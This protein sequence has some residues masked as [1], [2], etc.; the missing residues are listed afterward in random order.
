MACY[1]LYN[2]TANPVRST[3]FESVL[4]ASSIAAT[5]APCIKKKCK[6]QKNKNK[7]ADQLLIGGLSLVF[8]GRVS[9]WLFMDPGGIFLLSPF[10]QPDRQPVAAFCACN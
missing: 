2:V 9:R 3:S 5:C 4:I 6:A 1:L 7:T 8:V 10:L